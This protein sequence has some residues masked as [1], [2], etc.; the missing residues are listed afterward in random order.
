MWLEQNAESLRQHHEYKIRLTEPQRLWA[1][2]A[3][4]EIMALEFEPGEAVPHL[5]GRTLLI[6][7]SSEQA[8]LAFLDV[9][10]NQVR[11]ESSADGVEYP[12]TAATLARKVRDAHEHGAL[13]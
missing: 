5:D 2:R 4:A 7:P 10:E 3:I 1:E 6:P 13:P 12:R 8:V 11:D 9:L